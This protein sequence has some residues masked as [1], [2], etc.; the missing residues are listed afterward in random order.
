M[1]NNKLYIRKIDSAVAL[2]LITASEG[3]VAMSVQHLHVSVTAPI[4]TMDSWV[5]VATHPSSSSSSERLGSN[6]A[7]N[8]PV[9]VFA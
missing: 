2:S 1:S 8:V 6:V 5:K 3:Y 7:F 4:I 9:F